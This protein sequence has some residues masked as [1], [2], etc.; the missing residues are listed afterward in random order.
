MIVGEFFSGLGYLIGLAVLIWAARRKGL[1]TEG[2]TLIAIA[3]LAGGI[4]GA[5]LTELMFEG[6]PLRIGLVEGLDPRSGGRALL[7]GLIFGWMAVEFAKR[8]LGIKRSTGDLFA[9]AL[10]AG[11]AV[12]RIGCYFNT[13]CYGTT[14]RLPWSVYQH[15]AWRH[16]TQLYSSATA[17]LIFLGLLHLRGRFAREGDLFKV[18]LVAFGAS[19]FGLEFLRENDTFW[20][21][22]TPMQWFCLELAL[23]GGI[24]LVAGSRKQ[25]LAVNS[26]AVSKADT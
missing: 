10:P 20:F 7:G 18:Y 3:G 12:G 1:A 9:L 19:R 6:W 2:M 13:C 8:R 15:G 23:F 14:C 22:L 16:P 17:A 24:T 21:G 4:L 26:G 5:K 11:E 25:A